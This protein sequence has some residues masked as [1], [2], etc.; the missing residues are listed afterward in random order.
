MTD[1]PP[2][3]NRAA[4][5]MLSAWRLRRPGGRT[6]VATLVTCAACLAIWAVL[7]LGPHASLAERMSWFGAGP[8]T[9]LWDGRPWG[10]VTTAFVHVEPWHVALNVY[11]LWRL[12]PVVEARIGTARWTLF[13]LA[14][15]FVSSAAQV[16][17]T[18]AGGIGASGALY[19]IF[20]LMWMGRARDPA[21]AAA[22]PDRTVALFLGWFALCIVLTYT[23]VMA[24]GNG[25]HGGGLAFGAAVGACWIVRRHRVWTGAAA[26]ALVAASMAMVFWCPWSWAWAGARAIKLH[27]ASELDLAATWYRRSL[28]LGADPAWAW[29]NLALIDATAGREDDV[30]RDLAALRR[31]DAGQASAFE[32]SANWGRLAATSAYVRRDFADALRL[33][34][35]CRGAGADPVWCWQGI[36]RSR[37][38]LGQMDAARTAFAELRRLDP[39][40][41]ADLEPYLA[42]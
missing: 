2:P 6:P 40:A 3:Q 8:A 18:G 10:L 27:R 12:G 16:A 24:I 42:K 9:D 38:A 30:T 41:G 39:A 35:R 32:S 37:I 34:E 21:F 31:A 11:W 7:T 28:E 17:V 26:V 15:A 23:R 29:K 36:T 13:Y 1:E 22:L 4:F 33:Y 5:P 25:A 19:G 14:A 20:G